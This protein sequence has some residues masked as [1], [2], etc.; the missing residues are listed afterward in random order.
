[1]QNKKAKAHAP[2]PFT[3]MTSQ[4]EEEEEEEG[5]G[6]ST[7]EENINNDMRTMSIIDRVDVTQHFDVV[8]AFDMPR[9]RFNHVRKTF[10]TCNDKPVLLGSANEKAA[11]YRDRFDIIKQRL[12]H[13]E[14]FC[15]PSTHVSDNDTYLKIAPIKT[16]IG[17]DREHFL[18]FGML[19]QL[20]EGKIFL[21]DEDAHIELDLSSCAYDAG[22]FTD[23]TFALVEGLYGDDHIFHAEEL[24][25]PPPESRALTDTF[26]SG[27]DFLG[28]RK[29]KV[30]EDR[31]KA[32]EVANTNVF[33]AILSNVHLDEPR[34][35][36]ALRR[37]FEGYENDTQIPLAFIL[38]GDFCKD[39]SI[40]PHVYKDNFTALADLIQEFRGI[41]THSYFVFVPG[42]KDP[43]MGGGSL[44]QTVIPEWFT[45]RMRG[46][47]RNAIF[48]SNPCRI[49][50]CTQDIVVFREDLFSR[51][52][53]NSLLFPQMTEEDEPTKHLVRTVIDQG[54]LCPVPLTVKPIY[55]AFDHA[56][57]LYPLP[58]A[59]ILADQCESF[60]LT[61]EGTHC[62]CP[63]SFPTSDFSWRTYYPA[64]RLSEK[65]YT[66]Y[67]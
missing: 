52:W 6:D 8:S 11:L 50:Y 35:M 37:V 42:N 5:A 7:Q 63:G 59:L 49:R 61:Y 46:R 2:T 26:Y 60:G 14:N 33:F 41:A 43:S 45:A 65:W 67:L 25:F 48:A 38:C 57:R 9:L 23:G 12:M 44:P 13:N 55:W 17:R 64:T 30:E 20:E 66:L 28:L 29:L 32:E 10:I 18:L 47:V 15:P 56:L 58:H 21:E 53:R 36:N 34:V 16:L 39:N 40:D 19:T 4:E 24:G 27:V 3:R 1:M 54:H 51:L 62:I 22:M 31:L